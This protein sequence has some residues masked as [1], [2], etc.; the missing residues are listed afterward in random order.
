[1]GRLEPQGKIEPHRASTAPPSSLRISCAAYGSEAAQQQVRVCYP[2]ALKAQH[3]SYL[4]ALGTQVSMIDILKALGLAFH[5]AG[6]LKPIAERSLGKA[7]N[8]YQYHC[9]VS[10]TIAPLRIFDHDMCSLVD[11]GALSYSLNVEP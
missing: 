7:C 8:N 6:M 3:R 10:D 2:E 11:S 9:G 1:M 4:C 5:E